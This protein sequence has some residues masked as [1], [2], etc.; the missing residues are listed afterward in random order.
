MSF[1][2]GLTSYAKNVM[3]GKK[4]PM[5]PAVIKG[6]L[7]IQMPGKQINIKTFSKKNKNEVGNLDATEFD[8]G[9]NIVSYKGGKVIV[10][11]VGDIVTEVPNLFI[12]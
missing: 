2:E 10:E 12:T 8:I 9:I 6:V 7:S 1:R 4:N 3:G 11:R 5:D